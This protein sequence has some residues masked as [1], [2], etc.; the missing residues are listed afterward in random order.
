MW[1]FSRISD[2]FFCFQKIKLVDGSMDWS[3]NKTAKQSLLVKHKKLTVPCF[4]AA[5]V[6][7]FP[8]DSR[9]YHILGDFNYVTTAGW[10]CC[11]NNN[12]ITLFTRFQAKLTI[13]KIIFRVIVLFKKIVCRNKSSLSLGRTSAGI[14]CCFW[15]RLVTFKG[16]LAIVKWSIWEKMH[17]E[18]KS[19][20]LRRKISQLW[21][22]IYSKWVLIYEPTK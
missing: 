4:A 16:N 21:Y 7:F 22:C 10:F 12:E 8:T 11:K 1:K 20:I 13:I 18:E 14:V 19:C 3:W 5:I 17:F 9:L 15:G 6:N 2:L